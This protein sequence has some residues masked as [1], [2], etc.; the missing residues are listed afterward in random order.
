VAVRLHDLRRFGVGRQRTVDDVPYGGG[1]GMVLRPEPLF[2]AVEWIRSRYPAPS[3]RVILLS[4][5]GT[6]LEHGVS[7]RLAEHGRLILLCGRYEGVDERVRQGLADEEISLADVVLTGGELPALA[8]VDATSRFVSGVLG[9]SGAAERESFADGL[10]E[11]PYYTRPVEFRG[12]RVPAVLRSGNHA[13]IAR[14]REEK[15]VEVTRAKRPDLLGRGG[16][17]A[18][19]RRGEE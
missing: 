8:V 19:A 18:P 1:G 6:R 17:K 2:G 14:W 12:L 9:Q 5:Q 15:A 10:L 4:P 7:R 16:P 3:D 13:A 11:S